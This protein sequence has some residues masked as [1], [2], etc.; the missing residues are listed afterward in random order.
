MSQR[1]ND[2]TP[3][4]IDGAAGDCASALA[5]SITGAIGAPERGI[6]ALTDCC[7]P[8]RSCPLPLPFEAALAVAG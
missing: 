4:P 5:H 1:G 2:G 3:S 6:G 7:P 8:P